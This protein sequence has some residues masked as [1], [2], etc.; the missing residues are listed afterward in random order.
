M[1]WYR[2]KLVQISESFPALGQRGF[3]QTPSES[4]EMSAAYWQVAPAVL[5]FW[6][7]SQTTP[8]PCSTSDVTDNEAFDG[9]QQQQTPQRKRADT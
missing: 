8:A 1:I 2:K 4:S 7:I 5:C 3:R 6:T 9:Q